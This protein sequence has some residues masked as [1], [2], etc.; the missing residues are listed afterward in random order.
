MKKIR[1]LDFAFWVAALTCMLI[2]T[3]LLTSCAT[4]GRTL[5]DDL[6][7]LRGLTYLGEF[8]Y[9]TM[10]RFTDGTTTCY[11][12]N[13]SGYPNIGISCLEK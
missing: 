12:A 6:K 4:P 1:T 9:I 5:H 13:R 3:L 8:D 10:Y 2:M 7:P 11:I